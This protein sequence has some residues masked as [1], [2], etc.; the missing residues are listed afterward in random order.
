MVVPV[1]SQDEQTEEPAEI[2]AYIEGEIPSIAVENWTSINIIVQDAFGINWTLLQ[3]NVP[4]FVMR[5]IWPFNPS[6]PQPVQ[7]FLGETSFRFEPEIIEGDPRGWSLRVRPSAV[8]GSV[9]G[10]VYNI[11]LE[12]L[13]DDSAVD[14]A[15]V[16]GI[17]CT[18]IDTLGGEIGS[19]Y[20]YI[21]IIMLK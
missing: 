10:D 11:S 13:T 19:S 21:P 16:V 7:R 3:K 12:A 17:K 18:R 8:S 14:Y 5:V 2:N 6:F 4:E 20:I 1:Q 9:T 15:V